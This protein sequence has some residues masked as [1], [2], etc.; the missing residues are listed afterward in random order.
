M[1][2]DLNELDLKAAYTAVSDTYKGT[3]DIHAAC[4]EMRDKSPIFVG[5]FIKQFGVPTNAGLQQG[6][7][8][9]FA[10]FR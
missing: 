8:P 9:T 2:N 4:R 10:L 3:G 6:T 5:D 7:R 1:S